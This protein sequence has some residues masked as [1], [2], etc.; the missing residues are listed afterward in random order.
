M[1]IPLP[2]FL[3]VPN[4]QAAGGRIERMKKNSEEIEGI[5]KN[6]VDFVVVVALH[7]VF[8]AGSWCIRRD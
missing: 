4:P 3:K 6:A 5:A 8:G 2:F 1:T 7:A